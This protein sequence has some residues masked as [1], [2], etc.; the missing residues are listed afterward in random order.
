ME[1]GDDK[2]G[3]SKEEILAKSREENKNGDERESQALHRAAFTATGVGFLLYG[4]ITIVLAVLDKHSY[5]MNVVTF[6]MLG[7]MY[8]IWGIKTTKRKPL[9]LS[10]GVVCIAACVVSLACWIMELCGVI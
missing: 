10:T 7:T 4:I 6:G 8:T 5:E 9:F 3:L 2:Q 1:N